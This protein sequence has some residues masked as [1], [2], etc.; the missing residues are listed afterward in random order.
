[1]SG[2]PVQKR[3][4]FS[5]SIR[6]KLLLINVT[7]LLGVAAYAIYE[8]NSA[9]HLSSLEHASTEN[10]SS[11]I[12][13]LMLRRHEKDYLARRS[14]KYLTS[15]DA[16]Y[17]QLQQR[18]DHLSDVLASESI[19]IDDQRQQI[20]TTLSQ[21]QTQFHQLAAQLANIDAL[22][23]ELFAARSML[24]TNVLSA[25]DGELTAQFLQLLDHDLTFVT[26]PTQEHKVALL[27]GL[28]QFA[29]FE[30]DL[31]PA[32]TDYS[33]TLSRYVSAIETL[34]LT[35]N[36][37]LRG[38]LRSNV[39]KT[40]QAIT[41][42][43]TTIKQGVEQTA[44]DIRSHLQWMGVV[45]V[46]LLSSLLYVIGRSILSRIKAI[47]LLMDDIANG[48]GDLTVRMN[49]KGSDELAQLSRSFD[50]FISHLHDNIKQL[51]SVMDVLG[52]S[53]CSSEQAA[54]RSMQN[55]Q[56]VNS[57]A[58]KALQLTHATGKRIDTLAISIEE[59]Q[60]QIQALEAQSR[61]I[62]AVV[63]AIQGI[64]EQTNL[65]ALNAAIEA[66]R[67]GESG[68]GFAVVAD[69]VRQLSRL[70]NDST[71]QIESTV[72]ALTK[73]IAQTVNKMADSVDQARTT[74]VDTRHVIEAIEGISTQI[75]E[76]FDMN[77]QIAT[78]SEEQSMVSAEI[79]RNITQIAQLAGDTYEIVSGSVRCSEQV[80][81]VSHKLEKIVA[82]FKY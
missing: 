38:A 64:A 44:A 43:Q 2:S 52:E 26:E 23:S 58:D 31:S 82:Q 28:S 16:T 5:F 81:D 15:F 54:Q 33:N 20:V 14:E 7:L 1:M 79:D 11:S 71:L 68:R 40:E 67:A 21:Y 25:N 27:E 66:A 30:A 8:N 10:L 51:A 12:D 78:A 59:S 22:Q 45:I 39:H 17:S 65:L 57:E 13:L 4:F 73:G 6:A 56:R 3:F 42:L 35:A 32:F 70:T 72:Q 77:T 53:S 76:M 63:S 47:N 41:D 29:K 55:A 34:G 18:I 61:E 62:N 75:T 48:S 37:G 19:A 24:K 9:K 69:E 80:S 60:A 50:L 46:V 49:A 74:N 36:E